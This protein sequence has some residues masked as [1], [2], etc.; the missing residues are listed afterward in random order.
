MV[1]PSY[2]YLKLKS[3]NGQ[4][5]TTTGLAM[6]CRLGHAGMLVVAIRFQNQDQFWVSHQKV[7]GHFFFEKS[8]NELAQPK[9]VI[10]AILAKIQLFS[11]NS[12]TICSEFASYE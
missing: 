6:D 3:Q 11:N 2:G 12:D 9:M 1:S 4:T 5:G 7:R 8:K 10:L